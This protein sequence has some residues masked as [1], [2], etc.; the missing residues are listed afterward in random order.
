MLL[1]INIIT[2]S[3]LCVKLGDCFAKEDV[4]WGSLA[5]RVHFQGQAYR[6]TTVRADHTRKSPQ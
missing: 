5:L 4:N 3:L 2:T 1:I 6:E